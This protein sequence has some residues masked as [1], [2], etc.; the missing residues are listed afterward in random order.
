MF[1]A[2]VSARLNWQKIHV[3]W[4]D[5]RCVPPASDQSNYKLANDALLSKISIPRENVHRIFGEEQPEDGARR[6]VKEIRDFFSLQEGQTPVFDVIHRGIGPDAHTASLFP[7]EPLIGDSAGIAAAVWVEKMHSHRVTL[8][9]AVLRA[10]RHTVIQAAGE[11]KA[12]PIYNVLFGPEDPFAYPCQIAARD[13]NRAVW[14]LDS[15][16]AARLKL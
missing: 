9:P 6:Y 10:A 4:V 15:L 5:E 11:D 3:F 13:S 12:E 8:L 14:F 2:L 1:G 16:A 7:G